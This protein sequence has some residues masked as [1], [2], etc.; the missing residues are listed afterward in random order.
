MSSDLEWATGDVPRSRRFDDIYYDA[1]HGDEESRFN[2]VAGCG[3][4]DGWREKPLYVIGETGFGT[5]LNFLVTLEAWR[6][7]RQPGQRLHFVSVEG[8]PLP[9]EALV[10]AHGRFEGL[11]SCAAALQA[12]YPAAPC[13]GFHRLH[14]DD[15]GVTLDL[16]V[17]EAGEMLAELEAV[18][19]AWFLDGFA[20]SRNPEMWRHQVLDELARLSE[21]GTRLATFTAAGNVRRGLE[22]AGFAVHRT[23]GF[24]Q[25]R[26]R[27]VARFD[28][29]TRASE[30]PAWARLACREGP[31]TIHGAGIAGL[32]LSAALARRG[33]PH[34]LDDNG[35][36]SASRVPLAMVMPRLTADDSVPGRFFHQ[37]FGYARDFYRQLDG[38]NECGAVQVAADSAT[39]ERFRRIGERWAAARFV[40]ADEAATHAGLPLEHAG[41]LIETAGFVRPASLL[42]GLRGRSTA[43]ADAAEGAAIIA[44]GGGTA[45]GPLADL[46]PIEGY[47]GQVSLVRSNGILR[48]QRSTVFAGDYLTPAVDGLHM[49]GS[50]YDPVEPASGEPAVEDAVHGRNVTSIADALALD[51]RLFDVQDGWA[52]IRAALPDRL[53]AVGFAPDAAA[54]KAHFAGLRRGQE[55]PPMAEVC[56]YLA[57][58]GLGARGFTVAPLC[59]ELLVSQCVGEPWPVPRSVALALAPARFLMRALKRRQA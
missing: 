39:E 21:I 12:R 14:F 4:P 50:T 49:I 7:T 53:P 41:L 59:A 27:I 43:T 1:E 18:V 51:P 6:A 47:R 35:H 10:R 15:D 45:A 11:F 42:A 57:L 54:F 28:G 23:T 36:A 30:I 56:D 29:P 9:R 58:T 33:I 13:P 22:R 24:G 17:G 8:Q 32:S 16:L 3:L 37:A 19:D 44:M 5:G 34:A 38:W 31:P 52:G 2:F 46:L 40:S 25:K 55:A 20:P 26:E 48:E